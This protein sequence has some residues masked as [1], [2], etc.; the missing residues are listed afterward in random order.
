MATAQQVQN[1]LDEYN[2]YINDQMQAKGGNSD[3]GNYNPWGWLTGDNVDTMRQEAI[4]EYNNIKA[5]EFNASEAE[6][7][8]NFNA[9]QAQ[10]AR[11]FEERMSNTAYQRAMADAQKAG[12]NILNA[13][14]QQAST[15]TAAAA[16][17]SGANFT[18]TT[19][20]G[21]NTDGGKMILGLIKAAIGLATKDTK[22]TAKGVTETITSITGKKGDQII[23]QT[24]KYSKGNY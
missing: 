2:T 13:T 3:A 15:P 11:D 24:Q 1:G 8:R 5:R 6:K 20:K 18:P 7:A 4:A 10:L 14:N 17:G 21:N 9:Q 23:K 22:M 19:A 16:S 12:I